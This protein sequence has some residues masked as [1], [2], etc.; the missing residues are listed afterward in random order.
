[1]RTGFALI[2]L[3]WLG[4]ATAKPQSSSSGGTAPASSN[5]LIGMKGGV[6]CTDLLCIGGLINGSTAQY[7][8]QTLGKNNFGFMAMGFGETMADTPMV[9]MWA[10]T[11]GSITLSQRHAPSEVM[12][13]VDPNPPRLAT[14][15]ASLSSLSGPN[16][17]LTFTIPV[18]ANSATSSIII[19]A[20]GSTNPGSNAV[21]AI[22]IQPDNMGPI[23]LDLSQALTADARDPTNPI[24]TLS[25]DM[26][27]G[28]AGG[29]SVDVPLQPYQKMIVAHA[30]LCVVGFLGLLPAGVL[31][32]RYSRTFTNKW[33][34]GHWVFQLVLAGPI[35]IAGFACGISA[36]H[37]SG[38]KVKDTHMD[39]GIAIFVL[40]VAQFVLGFVIHFFKPSSWTV[41][42][43]RPLQ[44]YGHAILG[45][46]IIG[47]SFYQ[48]RLGY[49]TEWV[50]TTGRQ[51]ISNAANIV[52]YV[53]VALIPVLYILGLAL[54]PRQ[55][56]QERGTTKSTS[57]S[58]VSPETRY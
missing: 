38:N 4:V 22:L 53:W 23:G 47:L 33:F 54:L 24:L 2:V 58:D 44:N 34:F 25:G 50:N 18:D 12:P 26:G 6:T 11:D 31:I 56:K 21:D 5:A 9:I 35:I 49:H 41:D 57:D 7:T 15:Q 45:L 36:V 1:M 46:A 48:V 52:W 27:T 51:P 20:S 37:T 17:K 43:R 10:N 14:S 8:L 29:G 3:G 16:Q 55:W 19:W 39:L 30:I 32:A 28:S 40:Y 42:Q 13:T